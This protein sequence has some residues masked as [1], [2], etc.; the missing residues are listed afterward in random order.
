MNMQFPYSQI[1]IARTV[2]MHSLSKYLLSTYVH[3][4]P[5]LVT[6]DRAV[7]QRGGIPP[8]MEPVAQW[9]VTDNKNPH[10]QDAFT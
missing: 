1:Y 8:S 9:K 2:F 5:S 10:E 3:R 4:V 7:N 6:G